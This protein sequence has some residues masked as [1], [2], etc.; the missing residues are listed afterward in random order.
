[1]ERIT[2]NVTEKTAQEWRKVSPKFRSRLEKYLEQRI[3]EFLYRQKVNKLE[4]L[5]DEISDEAQANG[6]TE[7]ILQEILKEDD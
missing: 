6:L 7:E 5:L 2:I 1:M 4:T 3:D